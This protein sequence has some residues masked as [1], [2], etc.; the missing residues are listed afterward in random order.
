MKK[1]Y[2]R[3]RFFKKN[4]RTVLGILTAAMAVAGCGVEQVPESSSYQNLAPVTS[5]AHFD[6]E[7]LGSKVPCVVDFYAD[8]CGPCRKLKP[9][10]NELAG[11][12][13]GKVKFL[14][15]DVDKHGD[16]ARKYGISPIPDVRFFVGGKN[17]GGAVGYR[18]KSFWQAEIGKLVN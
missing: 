5:A 14:T 13:K 12:W 15:V 11:E 4:S 7:V 17:V 9:V 10:L 16:L 18:D 2:G 6:T 1:A 3:K 8:W